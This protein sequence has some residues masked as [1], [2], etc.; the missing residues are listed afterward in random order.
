MQCVWKVHTVQ[1]KYTLLYIYDIL[2]ILFVE[3]YLLSWNTRKKIFILG[4]MDIIAVKEY[5]INTRIIFNYLY[6]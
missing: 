6:L 5:T 4:S 3:S 2:K 1:K